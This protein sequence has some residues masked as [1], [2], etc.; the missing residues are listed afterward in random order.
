MENI[1]LS[2]LKSR[3]KWTP[4]GTSRIQPVEVTLENV[5]YLI[6]EIGITRLADITDMDRLKIPNYSAVLP[7]TEDYIWVYGGKGPTK[8]H[9]KASAVMESIERYSSLP[10]NYIN[11]II[12][13]SYEELS[14][15]YNILKYNE[16]IEPISFSLDDK[17]IM[18]Y[19]VGY[20]LLSEKDILVPA[21]LA[22]FKYISKSPSV[23]PYAFYHTNGLASGNVIEEA[24]CHALCEVIERDATSIA[25]FA[26]SAFQ[27][28]I[29]R[30]IEN[31]FIQSGVNIKTIES[32]KFIDDNGVYPDVDLNDV[33]NESVK[34]LFK[35][36][37]NC[38][39]SLTVKDITSDL[40]IPT[41]VA[42]SVEWV[43]HDYGFLVEG[44][45][46]HPD[47]RIALIRAITEV[48]QS[49][50]A[51][52]QGSRD[53]LRKMKYNPDD[54]DD[55]RSW[56]FIKSTKII[57]FSDIKSY[58]NEDILDDIRL[59]LEKLKE[60][61]LK[62]VVIVDLTNPRLNI[63]VIRAIVPGL[64]TFKVNKSIVGDRAREWFKKCLNL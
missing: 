39:I 13:G 6:K 21:A 33:D 38:Q 10:R 9:A 31:S 56:Q 62:K 1:I 50:A 61:E 5:N 3:K 57:K 15:S 25:E 42:S 16:V 27:Y 63:P 59:I 26:S 46:T 18:D 29:L 4:K 34:E 23:N 20:D 53:D 41:F 24:I 14:R 19:C 55:K 60:K 36:F 45:G 2:T 37:E 58:Y 52:I 22:I 28:H 48:S 47:S 40:G 43:N 17:M 35:R 49:R 51:N 32:K 44:H 11:K 30:T 54:S 64:E 7:G 8:N 12:K